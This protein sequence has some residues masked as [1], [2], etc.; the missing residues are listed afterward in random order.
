VPAWTAVPKLRGK[1]L[2]FEKLD[3]GR[4]FA[5]IRGS[6]KLVLVDNPII[7]SIL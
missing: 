7:F 1:N 5:E 3:T 6:G 2:N 4:N